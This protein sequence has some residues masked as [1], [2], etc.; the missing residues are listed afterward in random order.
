MSS[1]AKIQGCA[2]TESPTDSPMQSWWEHLYEVTTSW[3]PPA[4][5]APA[6]IL[7]L[8]QAEASELR[9]AAPVLSM[10][11]DDPLRPELDRQLVQ[12]RSNRVGPEP[13]HPVSAGVGYQG[14]ALEKRRLA[15]KES[16][17]PVGKPSKFIQVFSW[18]AGNLERQVLG[19]TLNDV[20]ASQFHISCLQEAS[21][22]VTSSFPSLLYASRG[23]QSVSSKSLVSMINA[24]GTG[25][26]VIKKCHDEASMH[27]EMIHRPNYY[28]MKTTNKK[29]QCVWYLVADVVAFDDEQQPLDRGGQFMWRVCTVHVCNIHAKKPVGARQTLA[30]FFLLMMRDRVD[31]VTRDFNQS[32][33]ILGEVLKE[34]SKIFEKQPDGEKVVWTIP[35]QQEEI[36][37]ASISPFMRPQK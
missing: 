21:G 24:G 2:E 4:P 34:A 29:M 25:T 18:N 12:N 22:A 9:S 6:E 37:C 31:I 10:P 1:S 7:R 26:K 8:M 20:I 15:D 27:C 11:E 36:R 30:D 33:H 19:D 23:I 13:S 5:K 14:K 35:G 17:D 32:Y 3:W 28:G 16:W